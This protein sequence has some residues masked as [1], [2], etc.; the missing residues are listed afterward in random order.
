MG[1]L[2]EIALGFSVFAEA[3]GHA[4]L[5]GLIEGVGFKYIKTKLKTSALVMGYFL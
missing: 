2:H 4:L 1:L 5:F 3:A